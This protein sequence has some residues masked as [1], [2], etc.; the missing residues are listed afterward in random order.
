MK[1]HLVD[2]AR[3]V[4]TQVVVL[5]ESAEAA[6]AA[7]ERTSPATLEAVV[8]ESWNPLSWEAEEWR[9][10]ASLEGL[11]AHLRCLA[12]EVV[13]LVDVGSV[14]EAR[15]ARACLFR[16]CVGDVN[17]LGCVCFGHVPAEMAACVRTAFERNNAVQWDGSPEAMKRWKAYASAVEAMALQLGARRAPG[18]CV[19]EEELQRLF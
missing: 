5:A 12:A 18:P 9:E 10:I 8:T 13:G 16:R 2:V 14:A 19:S 7:F 3:V 11:G 6:Q 17:K 4:R 15:A 1:M